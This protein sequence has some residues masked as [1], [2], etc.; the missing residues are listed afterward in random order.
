MIL[1]LRWKVILR[2][3]LNVSN[4]HC[5]NVPAILD[6][7]VMELATFLM[8]CGKMACPEFQRVPVALNDGVYEAC[9]VSSEDIAEEIL[10]N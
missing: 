7:V 8:G 4:L 3:I 5:E 1:A 9:S 2:V 6:T 10:R